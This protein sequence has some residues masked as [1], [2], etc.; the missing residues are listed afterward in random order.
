MSQE[1]PTPSYNHKVNYVTF[2][3]VPYVC[4]LIGKDFPSLEAAHEALTAA[5]HRDGFNTRIYRRR[6]S[7][8]SPN[9]AI[10]ECTH[11]ARRD[12]K[13]MRMAEQTHDSKRRQG[14]T[15]ATGC[16]W[17]IAAKLGP[18][19]WSIRAVGGKG[20]DS[21]NH[22]FNHATAFP[23]YRHQV[24]QGKSEAIVNSWNSGIRPYQILAA[25]HAEGKEY[26]GITVRD[27]LNLLAV[28]R[29]DQLGGKTPIEWLFAQL[30]DSSKYWYRHKQD[31]KGHVTSLFIAPLSAIAML[32]QHPDVLLMDSTYKT[33]RFNL[34][35]FNVCGT[36]AN[37]FAFQ[38]ASC[39]LSAE[40][41]DNY[42]WAIAVLVELLYEHDIQLPQVTCTDREIA[43]LTALD[44]NPSFRH[45]PH[46][47][48]R[49]HVNLNVLAKTR[50]FFPAATKN[51]DGTVTRHPSFQAFL[52]QWNKVLHSSTPAKYADLLHDLSSSGYPLKAVEY[53]VNTWL[54]PWRAKIVA[55]WVNKVTHFGHVTTSIVE[56]SHASLKTRICCRTGDL[57]SVF[58]KLVVF[59]AEQA[60]RISSY[61]RRQRAKVLSSACANLFHGIRQ[62]VNPRA[63][64]LLSDELRRLA[65]KGKAGLYEKPKGAC[66]PCWIQVTHGL[67]C[68]HILW[69]H[70][71]SR[72][73]LDPSNIHPHWF[74]ERNAPSTADES[75]ILDPITIRGRG[76]PQG[77]IEAQRAPFANRRSK[78][79]ASD[80]R[81]DPSAF[82]HELAEEA[83][84]A[85]PSST[86]PAALGGGQVNTTTGYGLQRISLRD[87]YEAGTEHHRSYQRA[88]NNVDIDAV[89]E[90][91]HEADDDSVGPIDLTS[92]EPQRPPTPTKSRSQLTGSQTQSDALWDL[93][94]DEIGLDIDPEFEGDMDEAL[95]Q[96]EAD[97]AAD[98]AA[99]KEI[100]GAD[101]AVAFAGSE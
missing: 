54:N 69:D 45:V 55:A 83:A 22:P 58:D 93:E 8:E 38:V 96:Y 15:F 32:R 64:R 36:T 52:D 85:I 97:E 91:E 18:D 23:R 1:T 35:L 14:S 20:R 33:N 78:N 42:R 72:Q 10:F 88:A 13:Q 95:R 12:I 89:S 98:M 87:T 59:W 17:Q 4:P 48:C 70:I 28:H 81:R 77:S 51:P 56:S 5:S 61:E 26:D 62:H 25:L 47:L 100:A 66:S 9:I 16:R 74:W 46:L 49:W 24:L 2:P 40:K 101:T 80:T 37:N 34:P 63:L 57:R 68:K 60:E 67:P 29:R 53:V 6:P 75:L 86:A 41:E 7:A 19:G 99:M 76:R 27:I 92:P 79:P 50:R 21:H 11:A 73:S 3:H 43:L 31:A 44:T 90:A 71:E 94:D 65:T 30:E 84:L 39:F 82:E